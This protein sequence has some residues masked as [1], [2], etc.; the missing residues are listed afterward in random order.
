MKIKKILGVIL[1]SGYDGE[2]DCRYG[3]RSRSEKA[4]VAKGMKRLP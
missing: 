2:H 1:T 4:V 3:S